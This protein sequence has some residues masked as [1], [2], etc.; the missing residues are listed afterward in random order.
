MSIPTIP[1]LS[2]PKFTLGNIL[3][4]ALVA[5]VIFAAAMFLGYM[6]IEPF[7]VVYTTVMGYVGNFNPAAA[8]S[9]PTTI[10]ASVGSAAAIGAPLLA[11]L[12]N[13]KTQAQQTAAAAQNQ[14]GNLNTTLTDATTQLTQT[15]EA[16]T[17]TTHQ[18]T[19][20]TQY[21][22]SAE[23]TIAQL[24][25][26]KDQALAQVS[27]LSDIQARAKVLADGQAVVQTIV[28]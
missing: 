17:Q 19:D 10:L 12:N 13:A 23:E 9:D 25:R 8:I 18:V 21:K 24:Q 27:V 14:I 6:Q 1:K 7:T 22:T 15:K 16:L 26:E 3:K 4:I 5:V 28:K 2:L 20:L 11:A